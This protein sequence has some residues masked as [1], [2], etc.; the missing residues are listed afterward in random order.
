MLL[1]SNV[2]KRVSCELEGC[3][4]Y[5][6][7]GSTGK[8]REEVIAEP[9]TLEN[10]KREA[11]IILSNAKTQ[12]EL[13]LKEAAERIAL[14]EKEAYARAYQK[15]EEDARRLEETAR[16]EF[17]AVI[18]QVFD[19]ME[20]IKNNIYRET[21][22]ELLDLALSIA[23]RMVCRQLDIAPETIVDIVKA[24]CNQARDCKEIILHIPA[25][26]LE[27][28]KSQQDEIQNIL[29]RTEHLVIVADTNNKSGGCWIETEQ[30]YIDARLDTMFE[31]L[32]A[33]IKDD[34]Q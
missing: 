29:Y 13:M 26:Q 27:I 1:S 10:V 28:I 25:E 30:G 20:E 4:V 16:L 6:K 23:E 24:V 12:A 8:V 22:A 18:K 32:G 34:T 33:I 17:N 14:M 31:H 19:Q 3:S 15:G 11:Q 9:V 5:P 21:E 7:M 2:I